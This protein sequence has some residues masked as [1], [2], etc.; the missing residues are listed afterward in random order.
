MEKAMHA[1]DPDHADAFERQ[2]AWASVYSDR[3][4]KTQLAKFHDNEDWMTQ[5]GYFHPQLNEN[6]LRIAEALEVPP[7][8]ERLPEMLARREEYLEL[9]RKQREDKEVEG[10]TF[11]PELHPKSA[12]RTDWKLRNLF[13]WENKRAQ[14]VNSLLEA[15]LD[16]Q[17]KQ[18]TFVPTIGDKSSGI[19][20]GYSKYA[21]VH[22]RLVKDAK[23]RNRELIEETEILNSMRPRDFKDM[24]VDLPEP[25]KPSEKIGPQGFSPKRPLSAPAAKAVA[26]ASKKEGGAGRREPSRVKSAVRVQSP[27]EESTLIERKS[28]RPTSRASMSLFAGIE[29]QQAALRKSSPLI[30][31]MSRASRSGRFSRSRSI[32][33]DRFRRQREE[34]ETPKTSTT[35][36][37]NTIMLKENFKG[38]A[39]TLLS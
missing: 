27:E 26:S 31:R 1:M 5:N 7:L 24:W 3:L 16:E 8:V 4:Y 15:Q 19:A 28:V 6:S 13:R 10:V 29:A 36:G 22:D 14:K 30:G 21:Q 37:V 39:G 20:D 17:A 25:P 34:L 11:A 9:C 32:T 23:R 38:V 18:C 12:C 33:V 35:A 2:F